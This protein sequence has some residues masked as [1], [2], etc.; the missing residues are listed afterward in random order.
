MRVA[1]SCCV[2]AVFRGA[3]CTFNVSA[4]GL[5]TQG[6]DTAAI[7][8]SIIQTINGDLTFLLNV[9]I[10]RGTLRASGYC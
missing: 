6:V 4:V 1:Q 3:C 10:S 7:I 5:R 9:P 8:Q 2:I